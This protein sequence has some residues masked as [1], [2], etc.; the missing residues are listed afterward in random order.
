MLKSSK[1]ENIRPRILHRKIL[2]NFQM[3]NPSNLTNCPQSINGGSYSLIFWTSDDYNTKLGKNSM[4]EKTQADLTHKY[5]CKNPLKILQYKSVSVKN[6]NT[7]DTM[8]WLKWFY[9]RNVRV[10]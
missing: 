2:P 10:V 9:P 7:R 5:G 4:N 3:T 8:H 1:K 6:N